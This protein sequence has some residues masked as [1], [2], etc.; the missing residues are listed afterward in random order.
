MARNG[1]AGSPGLGANWNSMVS[2]PVKR[3]ACCVLREVG[4][5]ERGEGDVEPALL[6]AEV[7]QLLAD[8]LAELGDDLAAL[9]GKLLAGAPEFG[10]ELAG[11][12][13]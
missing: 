9:G 5:G 13:R 10:V 3:D 8:G 1:R 12:R 2:K 6:E 7:G 11:V 4:L